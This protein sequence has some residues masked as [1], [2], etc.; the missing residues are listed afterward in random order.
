MRRPLLVLL[1]VAFVFAVVH[2]QGLVAVPVLGALAVGFALTREW[3]DS[4]IPS[5]VAHALNN[6]LVMTTL[7]VA[8]G[9]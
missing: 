2:P 5:M 9:G 6:G 3:R 4:L 8:F 1:L 7:L